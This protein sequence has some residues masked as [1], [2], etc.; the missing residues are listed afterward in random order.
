MSKAAV[1]LDPTD[2]NDWA[3]QLADA[4]IEIHRIQPASTD[5]A[6]FPVLANTDGH[7]SEAETLAALRRHP[8]GMDLWARRVEILAIPEAGGSGL[9][10]P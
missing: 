4:L 1:L 9:C 3:S 6:L 2:P 8:L 10:P 5:R 7:Q